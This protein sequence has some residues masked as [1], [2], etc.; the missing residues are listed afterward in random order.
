MAKAPAVVRVHDDQVGFDAEV[1]AGL[2]AA[3]NLLEMGR[4]EP[5]EVPVVAGLDAEEG[6]RVAVV[7]AGGRRAG[8]ADVGVGSGLV[9]VIDVVLREDAEADLVEVPLGEL[10]EGLLDHFL[11][12]ERPDVGGCADRE[13]RGAVLIG[14]VEAVYPD[15]AVVAGFGGGGGEGAGVFGIREGTGYFKGVLPFVRGHET[16]FVDAVAVVEAVD[17]DAPLFAGEGGGDGVVG[18]GVAFRPARH[19]HFKDAPAGGGCG[20]AVVH[21]VCLLILEWAG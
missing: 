17:G 12:L 4:V 14:E 11:P 21:M 13:V 10:L 2:D 19:R 6:R 16:G 5:V 8:G 18:K 20:I 7:D 15:R 1:A 9:E 3:L